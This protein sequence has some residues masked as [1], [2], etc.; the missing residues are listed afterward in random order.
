[1]EVLDFSNGGQKRGLLKEVRF[2]ESGSTQVIEGG[3]NFR[4]YRGQT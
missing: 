2:R 1:M 3:T 4:F